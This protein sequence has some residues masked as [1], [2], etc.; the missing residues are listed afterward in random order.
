[1]SQE[2]E[3]LVHSSASAQSIKFSQNLFKFFNYLKPSE[4]KRKKHLENTFEKL[5]ISIPAKL[6]H[7]AEM[8]D[9][10]D[11][12]YEHLPKNGMLFYRVKI[13]TLETVRSIIFLNRHRDRN[14]EVSFMKMK[15]QIEITISCASENKKHYALWTPL[16]CNEFDLEDRI[17][18]FFVMKRFSDKVSFFGE[19]TGVVMFFRLS[20]RANKN[21]KFY[22]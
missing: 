21:K 17:A 16:P 12:L 9:F 13:A 11:R 20:A 3:I 22:L 10:M 6:N 15:K 14:I 4:F 2:S 1:M 7:I 8:E 19:G 5:T 18:R